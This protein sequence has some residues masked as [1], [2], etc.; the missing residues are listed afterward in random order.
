MSQC[1]L[2]EK[3][4]SI[5]TSKVHLKEEVSSFSFPFLRKR[6]LPLNMTNLL[7]PFHHLSTFHPHLLLI[8]PSEERDHQ[9]QQRDG[10]KV[11][12]SNF[13]LGFPLHAIG[14]NKDSRV[15]EVTMREKEN[16]E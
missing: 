16:V 15:L 8:F 9:S 11:Q 3:V 14:W 6:F 1:Q 2:R 5:T 12:H 10:K 4:H 7:F 13:P